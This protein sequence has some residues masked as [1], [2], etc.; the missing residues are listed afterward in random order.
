M[1]ASALNFLGFVKKF[2]GGFSYSI[3]NS[4]SMAY[5]VETTFR[6]VIYS[7]FL[8]LDL[9][10]YLACAGAVAEQL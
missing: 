5:L 2:P 8:V 3:P 6:L 10:E 7:L 4:R 1:K 9:F